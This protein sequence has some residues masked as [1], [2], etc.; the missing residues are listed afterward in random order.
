MTAKNDMFLRARAEY[1][2]CV[3]DGGCAL[4][5]TFTYSEK[6]V[7]YRYFYLTD[8][9]YICLS[10]CQRI[11]LEHSN[12][13]MVFDKEHVQLYFKSLR[14][15]L[16]K[17]FDLKDPH[18]RELCSGS[19]R[20]ICVSEY[21]SE[22]TQRPHYHII[23][24]L[25]GELF[26]RL[27]PGKVPS[28]DDISLCNDLTQYFADFWDYGIVSASTKGLFV[29]SDACA[30]Y[31][32]KYVCKDSEL[33]K[34]S[35]FKNLFDFICDNFNYRSGCYSDS[36]TG[37][38]EVPFGHSFESPMSFFLY[39]CRI[40]DC[41]F[42]VMKSQNFGLSLV[43]SLPTDDPEK[44]CKAVDRGIAIYSRNSSDIRY[45]RFP[46]YIVNKILYNHRDDGTYYLNEFGLRT[47]DYLRLSSI[48]KSVEFVHSFD[49]SLIDTVPLD[50]FIPL[51]EK[52]PVLRGSTFDE[53]IG[54]LRTHTVEIFAFDMFLRGRAFDSVSFG[55]ARK[56]FNRFVNGEYYSLLDF[57]KSMDRLILEPYPLSDLLPDDSITSGDYLSK[58]SFY[59]KSHSRF[60]FTCI[61]HVF[62]HELLWAEYFCAVSDFWRVLSTYCRGCLLNEYHIKNA[63]TKRLADIL[64]FNKYLHYGF[65]KKCS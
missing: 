25:S 49:M 24:Y 60:E 52:Y 17:L 50:V 35:R 48:C 53:L 32:S 33:L 10:R 4:F 64:N 1:L 23:F 61:Y 58:F 22:R 3:R 14:K 5:L 8:D 18:E 2:D 63:E 31:V 11:G 13:L 7:P 16:S 56:N 19:L 6:H 55:I 44:F 57:C 45:Y 47:V 65:Q 28:N 38:L 34:Y 59:N 51:Y 43:D 41:S 30:F 15:D 27:C 46:R 37:R 42:F 29:D 62:E 39:Y 20:Y 9:G 12:H 54:F 40:F 26:R 36:V 21:G